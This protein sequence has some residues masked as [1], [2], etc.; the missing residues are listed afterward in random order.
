M[1]VYDIEW[2]RWVEMLWIA[3][4]MCLI[5]FNILEIENCRLFSGVSWLISVGFEWKVCFSLCALI[6][7]NL[8][9]PSTNYKLK[10]QET[11]INWKAQWY[12]H[13]TIN[14]ASTILYGTIINFRYNVFYTHMTAVQIFLYD[15]LKR[16]FNKV[17]ETPWSWILNLFRFIH[18][19]IFIANKII[20]YIVWFIEFIGVILVEF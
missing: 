20:W 15:F 1:F 3:Q 17:Y 13:Q 9:D 12:R 5:I 11:K 14:L 18:I 19:D 4:G 8:L 2:N 6:L 7:W 10:F 16:W